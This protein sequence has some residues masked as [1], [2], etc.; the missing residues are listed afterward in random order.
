M[1]VQRRRRRARAVEVSW[2]ARSASMSLAVV[3]RTVWP[4]DEAW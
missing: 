3:K 4:R 2:A 1:R